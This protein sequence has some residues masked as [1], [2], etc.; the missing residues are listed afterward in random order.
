MNKPYV[1][2]LGA[3][4]VDIFGFSRK[5]YQPYNS[6]PGEIRMSLGGVCRNIADNLARLNINTKFVSVIGN[7]EKGRSILEHS[8]VIGYDMSESKILEEGRTATYMAVLDDHGEMVS[9]IVDMDSLD[10]LDI[11][12]ISSKSEL[13]KNAEYVFLDSDNPETMEYILKRFKGETRFILDPIS[14]EKAGSIR[15]LIKY[16]HTIKPNK[17]EA[18]V[19]S[20]IKIR[21]DEDLKRVGNHFIDLGVTEVFISLDEEGVYYNDGNLEGKIK[22]YGIPV[23]NVTG[24]GDSFVAGLGYGYMMGMPLKNRVKFA[25]GASILT[26]SHEDT[27]S[28]DMSVENINKILNKTKWIEYAL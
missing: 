5:K 16:F 9:A 3:S 21:N 10:K 25:I 13:I 23:K 1:L 15:H 6:T 14:A 8:K 22:T 18:E 17:Y 4:I 7:D 24:A 28:P 20:G 12:F 27:I 2:V 19:M 11:D 26:I